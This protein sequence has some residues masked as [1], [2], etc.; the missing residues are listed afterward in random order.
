MIIN[1]K[2]SKQI[3]GS[4]FYYDRLVNAGIQHRR[5]MSSMWIKP[6]IGRHIKRR[7]SKA[8][9]R[10]G[11]MLCRYGDENLQRVERGLRGAECEANWKGW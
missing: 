3:M 2:K 5:S 9:R 11:R 10:A 6:H 8:R 7:L 4:R 1:L